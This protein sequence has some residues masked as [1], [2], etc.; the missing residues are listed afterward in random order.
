MPTR[1][2]VPSIV[3]STTV[4]AHLRNLC[5]LPS[6]KA[7]TLFIHKYVCASNFQIPCKFTAR[8]WCSVHLAPTKGDR[9][10]WIE[11]HVGIAL[12][13]PPCSQPP[14]ISLWSLFKRG[15]FFCT[16]RTRREFELAPSVQ[17]FALSF[18]RPDTLLDTRLFNFVRA[19]RSNCFGH[20]R[21]YSRLNDLMRRSSILCTAVS[22]PQHILTSSSH[23]CLTAVAYFPTKL[24]ANRNSTT[25]LPQATICST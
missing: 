24:H 8:P 25:T 3:I 14:R 11:S 21:R 9:W 20:H 22:T 23:S 12:G 4:Y 5:Q 17:P 7:R 15:R 10:L 13:W 2:K 6:N 16:F 18:S 1:H 19:S